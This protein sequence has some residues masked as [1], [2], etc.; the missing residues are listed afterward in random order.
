MSTRKCTEYEAQVDAEAAAAYGNY[1]EPANDGILRW[2]SQR[3]RRFDKESMVN[4]EK[5]ERP[6][7]EKRKTSNG[8]RKR[9]D[10]R[11]TVPYIGPWLLFRLFFC[12][13]DDDDSGRPAEKSGNGQLD[14]NIFTVDQCQ[15]G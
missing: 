13:P 2:E 6:L 9:I 3:K 8:V 11:I 7:A 4:F 15:S 14:A 5:E 12:D 10:N 1:P